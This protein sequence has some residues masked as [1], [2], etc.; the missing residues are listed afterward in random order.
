MLVQRTRA[1]RPTSTHCHLGEGDATRKYYNRMFY[2]DREKARQRA[3]PRL[4]HRHMQGVERL[5]DKW[6]PLL[7]GAGGGTGEPGA[8]DDPY[9]FC[10]DQYQEDPEFSSCLRDLAVSKSGALRKWAR[11]ALTGTEDGDQPSSHAGGY[12]GGI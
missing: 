9:Y 10:Y 8:F 3:S 6:K 7:V 11:P 12:H 4:I 2:L 1:R 5:V